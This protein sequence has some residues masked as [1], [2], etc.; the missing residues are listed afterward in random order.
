M[1]WNWNVIY[2][3]SI[4]LCMCEEPE[5][6]KYGRWGES[7]QTRCSVAGEGLARLCSPGRHGVV[8]PV[9]DLLRFVSGIK[10]ELLTVI[11]VSFLCLS[12]RFHNMVSEVG[13]G[14]RMVGIFPTARLN[15]MFVCFL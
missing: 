3:A 7:R 14:H 2:M 6:H 13:S 5:Y 15:Q 4:I 9:K 12:P 10:T 11:C 1:C 8:W